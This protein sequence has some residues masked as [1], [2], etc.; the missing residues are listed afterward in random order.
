[1]TSPLDVSTFI[2]N[3]QSPPPL[4]ESLL[5]PLAVRYRRSSPS[6]TCFSGSDSEVLKLFDE[7]LAIGG[8]TCLSREATFLHLLH[9]YNIDKHSL[10][11][12][13]GKTPPLLLVFHA[14]H[15]Y[16]HTP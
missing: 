6:N 5:L 11:H 12:I 13:A 9:E 16:S 8:S 2:S 4:Q 14:N 1:M 7:L 10:Q 3:E 15:V